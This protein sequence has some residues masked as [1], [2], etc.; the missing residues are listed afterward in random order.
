MRSRDVWAEQAF[1]FSNVWKWESMTCST[2]LLLLSL[3]CG[4]VLP[5]LA[6]D[7]DVV[8]R[9]D[10]SLVRVD[11]QVVDRDNR[12]ITGLRAEDFILH[13]E[14]QPQRIGN[15]ASE[16][17]PLDVVLLLDVSA[18]MR[19]HVE[20]VASAARQALQVLRNKDRV[21]IM[22]FDRSTRLR[23]P[24]RNS[25]D[26]VERE[27]DSL[28]KEESFQGGTDITRGLLDAAEYV[29]RGGRRDARRAIVILTDDQTEYNRDVEGVSR[30]LTRAEAV[31]SLLLAP[32]AMAN[33]SRGMGGGRQGGSGPLPGGSSGGT[34]PGTGP[35]GGPLGGIILGRRGPGGRQGPGTRGPHTQ[36]AGTAEIARRSGG[37]NMPVDDASALET[38]LARIRQRYA[39]HFSLP[40]GAKPG[41]ERAIEVELAAAVRQ[42]YPDAEVRY[43]RAYLVPTSMADAS[44]MAGTE[45]TVITR[46]QTD[47]SDSLTPPAVVTSTTTLKRRPGVDERSTEGPLINS[48]SS[49]AGEAQP[50]PAPEGSRQLHAPPQLSAPIDTGQKDAKPRCGGW[51]RVGEPAPASCPSNTD[52]TDQESG[53]SGP[54]K[55]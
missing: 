29:A 10:V 13:D 41:Q 14:G 34:W 37:D 53:S 33:R 16:N 27:L 7:G 12:T 54:S 1:I 45:P 22:V 44:S 48:A 40:Q 25:R 8:F 24:F 6:A 18:S 36:S 43:R 55:P 47:A 39:L 46:P 30:A 50:N 2:C 11:A 28:L 21:A 23:L 5:A 38:T 32:D 26:D 4:A 42:R 3:V 31:L 17:M 51:H 9:S 19:P 49:A 35:L 52:T 15:F 20:R